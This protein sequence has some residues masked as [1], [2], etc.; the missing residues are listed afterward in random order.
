MDVKAPAS[1]L[2]DGRKLA[3]DEVRPANPADEKGTILLLTGLGSKRLGVGAA[4]RRLWS[5]VPHHCDGPPR[6]WR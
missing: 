4:A 1:V 2:I 3:Y 6:H 5:R